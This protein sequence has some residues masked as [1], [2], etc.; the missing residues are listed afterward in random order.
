M[1][2]LCKEGDTPI[3]D[4]KRIFLIN[5]SS[6]PGYAVSEDFVN[7]IPDNER[8]HRQ[9]EDN[10]DGF[11]IR[12][13]T[14]VAEGGIWQIEDFKISNFLFSISKETAEEC[15]PVTSEAIYIDV[16]KKKKV[17]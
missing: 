8:R 5:H 17:N 15:F 10:E 2:L 4:D 3:A 1:N 6:G 14:S 9:C 7:L 16:A 11:D 13:C 12:E